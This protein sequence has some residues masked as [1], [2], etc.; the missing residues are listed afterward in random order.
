MTS[1][2]TT[3]QR[4]RL[5]AACLQALLLACAPVAHAQE[6][7]LDF[8]FDGSDF[9]ETSG[10]GA[11][12]D[13]TLKFLATDR[14]PAD[15]HSAAGG[16][17]SGKP[18]DKALDLTSAL[19]MGGQESTPTGPVAIS[20]STACLGGL[21]SFT[22]QGWF[23][24]E[25]QA[26]QGLARLV[27][28]RPSTGGE[29][30]GLGVYSSLAPGWLNFQGMGANE[31]EGKFRSRLAFDRADEWYFFAI[32]YASSTTTFYSGTTSDSVEVRGTVQGVTL[33]AVPPTGEVTVGNMK[34]GMRPFKGWIDNVRVFG[35]LTDDT[36]ALSME[37]LD[38]L[39]L[40]DVRGE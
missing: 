5:T 23:K 15:L 4:R 39:R 6:K 19:A 9:E 18:G 22:I 12:G 3:P 27:S 20:P 10:R 25:G 28:Y 34:Y 26:I 24:G 29:E 13:L 33:E 21:T 36:G 32:T 35:S 40:A 38:E 8:S 37:Q 30:A 31:S 14:T 2:R 11:T 1:H 16:G 17:V 7:I